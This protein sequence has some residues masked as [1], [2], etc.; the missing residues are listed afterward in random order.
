MNVNGPTYGVR[1]A[2]RLPPVERPAAPAPTSPAVEVGTVASPS[3]PR[4][5]VEGVPAGSDP[6]LWAILTSEERS[7]FLRQ[8][9]LGPLSYGPARGAPAPSGDAPVGQRIDVRA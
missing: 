5:P 9:A 7:F 1:S 8:A 3:A 2:Y 4:A 6:A